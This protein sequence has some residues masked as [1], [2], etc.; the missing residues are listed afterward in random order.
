MGEKLSL[1]QGVGGGGS[2][3]CI[4]SQVLWFTQS[5]RKSQTYGK[6][7]FSRHCANRTFHMQKGLICKNF[8]KLF[9][10]P[11]TSRI[12]VWPEQ[13]LLSSSFFSLPTHFLPS[14][15][16]SFSLST[17]PPSCLFFPSNFIFPF[18]ISFV[19]SYD[20]GSHLRKYLSLCTFILTSV[21]GIREVS[22][23]PPDYLQKFDLA[24]HLL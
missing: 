24:L 17:F 18:S 22:Y 7:H 23:Q 3:Y 16:H 21:K 14:F 2:G 20:P 19:M 9:F 13:A 6:E 5:Q 12:N 8:F 15:S 1:P 10:W 4:Q 11:R